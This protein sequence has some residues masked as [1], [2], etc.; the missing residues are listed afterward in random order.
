MKTY[1]VQVMV[2]TER[3]L[4][5]GVERIRDKTGDDIERVAFD[6]PTGRFTYRTNHNPE[7]AEDVLAYTFGRT[8]VIECRWV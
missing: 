2:A 8:E 1:E 4:R 7:D 6:F 5:E 3:R